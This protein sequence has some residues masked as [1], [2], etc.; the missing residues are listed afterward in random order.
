MGSLGLGVEFTTWPALQAL[1]Y[2]RLDFLR[3]R[4]RGQERGQDRRFS[5]CVDQEFNKPPLEL[6]SELQ[7]G[8]QRA[9]RASARASCRAT[10]AECPARAILT[11]IVASCSSR[12]YAVWKPRGNT[13]VVWELQTA[14][15]DTLGR[16]PSTSE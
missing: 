16:K 8:P 11:G 12:D 7:G 1:V 14:C 4:E 15:R 6:E 3:L 9:S 10:V 13:V 2:K 5:F